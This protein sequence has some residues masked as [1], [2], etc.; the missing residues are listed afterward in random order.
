MVGENGAVERQWLLFA[1]SPN[2]YRLREFE[3]EPPKV[4]DEVEV[5]G[6]R[7]EIVKVAASPLPG[8]RRRCAY[9]VGA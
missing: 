1:W 2:G 7:L 9:T 6:L 3:G 8:D 4:G 5:D